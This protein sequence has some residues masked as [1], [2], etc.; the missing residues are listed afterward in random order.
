MTNSSEY[1]EHP[2]SVIWEMRWRNLVYFWK[3][4]LFVPEGQA[5]VVYR[6]SR[7]YEVRG[8]GIIGYRRWNEKLGPL[9]HTGSQVANYE[10]K[11]LLSHDGLPVNI[12]LRTLVAY[13]PRGT[14]HD[15][16]RVLTKLPRSFYVSIAEAYYRWVLMEAVNKYQATEVTRNEVTKQIEEFLL[17][18]VPEE[19]GF[20]GVQPRGRPQILGVELPPPL[21]ERQMNIAQRR[22][23]IMAG[24]EFS[25]AEFRQALVTEV[26]EGLDRQGGGETYINFNELLDSYESKHAEAQPRIVE[27]PPQPI[28]S[29]PPDT[30]DKG[31]TRPSGTVGEE[32][33]RL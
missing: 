4:H 22:A 33:S 32:D 9:I 25:T 11:N 8:P 16:A 5:Q 31:A 10:F 17:K 19:M 3:K 7:Y 1:I 26:I 29:Q 14:L 27:N 2:P 6:N 18:K 28:I 12:S 21:T 30:S 24:G 13:D 20:L 23:N 15:I